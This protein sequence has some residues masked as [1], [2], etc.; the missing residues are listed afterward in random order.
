MYH[1]ICIFFV[2]YGAGHKAV[3]RVADLTL[4]TRHGETGAIHRCSAVERDIGRE[5]RA[6]QWMVSRHESVVLCCIADLNAFTRTPQPILPYHTLAVAATVSAPYKLS[7][8][9]QVMARS[10]KVHVN[11]GRLPHY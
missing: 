4:N 10:D 2:H 8:E 5:Q 11:A 7:A 9:T 6:A 3:K 1:N